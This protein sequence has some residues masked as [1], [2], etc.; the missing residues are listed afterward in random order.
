MKNQFHGA[1]ESVVRN[2]YNLCRN[3]NN[4]RKAYGDNVIDRKCIQKLAYQT[5][6]D[7]DASCFNQS[8]HEK[9]YLELTNVDS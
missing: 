5:E 1:Y 6:F 9:F 8:I 7:F 4:V 2:A 3:S